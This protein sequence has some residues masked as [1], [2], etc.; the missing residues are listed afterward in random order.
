MKDKRIKEIVKLSKRKKS[1]LERGFNYWS[2]FYLGLVLAMIMFGLE[3]INNLLFNLGL[4]ELIGI[5]YVKLIEFVILLIFT[6][7]SMKKLGDR[8]SAIWLLNEKSTSLSKARKLL[9]D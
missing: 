2:A 4:F 7:F 8:L 3:I 5:A 6:L 9:S 1:E